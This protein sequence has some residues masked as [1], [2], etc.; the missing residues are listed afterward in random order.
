M[1][2]TDLATQAHHTG[3]GMLDYAVLQRDVRKASEGGDMEAALALLVEAAKADDSTRFLDDSVWL[4]R[5]T[6]DLCRVLE[7]GDEA[8]DAYGKAFAL[9]PRDRA[10]A[11]PYSE[12]LLDEKRSEEGIKVVQALLL[13]HKRDLEADELGQIY[14]RLGALHEAAENYEMARHAFEKG[15]EQVPGNPQALTGL[16]RMVGKVGEP[17]DVIDVRLKLIKSLGNAEARSMALIALGD[18]WVG[19]FNDPGRA[20]DTYEQALVE[21]PKNTRAVERIAQVAREMGDA[22]RTC[23]AYFTLSKLAKDPRES[24]D[25]LIKSSEVARDELWEADKALAGFRQAL[26]LDS[27]RLD[28][29][30][31]VTSILVDARDWEGL[32][33]AYL[34]LIATNQENPNAEPKLLA[35]LWQK[36]GDLYKLHLERTGD[37]I[38]AYDRASEILPD[39]VELH[40]AVVELAEVDTDKLDIALR[41][42]Q[43]LRLCDE[44]RRDLLDRIG[45]VYLRKK[46]VDRAYSMFRA[47]RYMGETFDE[48]TESFVQRFESPIARPVKEQVS[49]EVLARYV[50][51][52]DLVPAISETFALLKPALEEWAGED[53]KKYGLK[54]KDQVKIE[55]KLAFNNLYRAIGSSL[56]YQR[57]P[58]IWH[59]ATQRGLINGALIPEG[60]IVGD[61]LLGSGREKHIAFVVAKQLFLFR[62][63]FY[64]AAIRPLSDLEGFFIRAMALARPDLQ[65]DGDLNNDQAFK[66]MKRQIKGPAFEKLREAINLLTAHGRDVDMKGWVEALEDSANRV[67]FLF[68][69]DLK[70]VEQYLRNDPSPISQRSIEARMK[71]LVD[72]SVSEK[73]LALRPRLGINVA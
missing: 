34:Q 28:A 21:S 35:V 10:I 61:E 60:L 58:D 26:E 42:L 9:E 4:Y 65:I 55:E 47:L 30:K 53:K 46:E 39:S 16:L 18:D 68:C 29:F 51:S 12:L 14:L 41:H 54:R 67:G 45:R 22:R 5:T 19:Q 64:L 43:A 11:Q 56:G 25:W 73:Y 17:G 36:L 13:N 38:T 37:A 48:K 33:G 66:A 8:L 1:A 62:P 49:M 70:V 15:L 72:Y 7:R 50:M 71:S 63:Q 52:T 24:A 44:G 23:R 32:E 59:S 57:L 6:A 69:D 2:E 31:A 27:T 40:E 20:L 3:Q